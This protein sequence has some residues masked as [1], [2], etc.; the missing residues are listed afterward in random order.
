MATFWMNHKL[1]FISSG[2]NKKSIHSIQ[3]KRSFTIRMSSK[4]KQETTVRGTSGKSLMVV[5]ISTQSKFLSLNRSRKH[6]NQSKGTG[7]KLFIGQLPSPHSAFRNQKVDLQRELGEIKRHS[8]EILFA[9]YLLI[10]MI[11]YFVLISLKIKKQKYTIWRLNGISMIK[12]YRMIFLPFFIQYGAL[13]LY[14]TFMD[15]PFAWIQSLIL[16][17]S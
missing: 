8:L 4:S 11:A 12:T 3:M 14:T 5:D 1:I 16:F 10:T 13:V 7:R 15:A 17:L 6:S 2:P 9:L